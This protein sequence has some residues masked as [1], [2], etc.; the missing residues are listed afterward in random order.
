[1]SAR[2]TRS[3]TKAQIAAPVKVEIKAPKSQ[4][5]VQLKVQEKDSDACCKRCELELDGMVAC[6]F[7]LT[8]REAELEKKEAELEKKEEELENKEE[9]LKMF[10]LMLKK[11]EAELAA[12]EAALLKKE[13]ELEVALSAKPA[14]KEASTKQKKETK[15]GKQFMINYV[16]NYQGM[17]AESKVFIGTDEKT[18]AL[19]AFDW[20]VENRS[21][22][23]FEMALEILMEEGDS[24]FENEEE[25]VAHV[26][27]TCNSFNDLKKICQQYDDSYF[28]N[29]DG[30][31]LKFSQK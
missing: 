3:Q 25:L 10:N 30:W 2:I 23:A 7:I 16:S 11:K 20:M 6:G 18:V 21:G 14:K 13:A 19:E 1:M 22:L 17:D 26:R 5:K 15:K 28:E 27:K 9:E 4:K 8:E 12:R 29:Y 31:K 24:R